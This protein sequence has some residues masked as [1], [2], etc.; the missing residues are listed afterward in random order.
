MIIMNLT[1]A[2]VID[3]LSSARKDNS[4]VIKKDEINK[5]VELWSEYDPKATGW[6]DVTNLVFLLYE[7]P[8]PLGY[9]KDHSVINKTA[10]TAHGNKEVDMNEILEKAREKR[11]YLRNQLMEGRESDIHHSQSEFSMTPNKSGLKR[12]DT[13]NESSKDGNYLL[14]RERKLCVKKTEAIKILDDFD[15][16]YYANNKVHFKDICKKVIDN[17][18][19]NKNMEVEIG[20]RLKT[21]LRRGWQKKYNLRKHKK[22]SIEVQK[23]MAATVLLKWI[24]IYR[25]KQKLRL[26][27]IDKSVDVLEKHISKSLIRDLHELE[28]LEREEPSELA[29]DFH[30]AD[31]IKEEEGSEDSDQEENKFPPP[32]HLRFDSKVSDDYRDFIKQ[33]PEYFK[34]ITFKDPNAKKP[35]TRQAQR[36]QGKIKAMNTETDPA[37]HS[38]I[39][40]PIGNFFGDANLSALFKERKQKIKK[41]SKENKADKHMRSTQAFGFGR[42][43]KAEKE[44]VQLPSENDDYYSFQ[45][46]DINELSFED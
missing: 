24:R 6:I 35:K 31:E 19:K 8:K 5:L 40:K 45:H 7:L 2:A 32:K 13:L 9:G 15:I 36:R 34:K 38:F 23:I 3:G 21:R 14:N 18:F 37:S 10:S 30:L 11:L 25:S 44:K 17:T 41:F 33:N 16:P 46:V 20:T 22:I 42:Q 26:E 12:L 29:E 4:G 28:E 39:R 43:S 1:V 27:A